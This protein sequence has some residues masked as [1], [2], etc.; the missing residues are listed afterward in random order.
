MGK[1]GVTEI[2]LILAVVLIFFGGK[3]IPELM[4]GMGKG[5]KEFKDGMKG[6]DENSKPGNDSDTIKK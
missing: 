3:K 5:I 1:F 6:D 4:K 2:L